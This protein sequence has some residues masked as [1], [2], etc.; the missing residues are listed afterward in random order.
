MGQKLL[1]VP[2][3]GN[4]GGCPAVMR[5]EG[6]GGNPAAHRDHRHSWAGMRSSSRQVEALNIRT[7]IGR[8]ERTIPTAVARNAVDRSI[9]H[10]VPLM[11]IKRRE[12]TLK[13]NALLDVGETSS[14]LQLIK[15]HLA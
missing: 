15:N 12:R 5:V 11:D 4:G 13:D 2:P 6:V 9:Q 7:G 8:L 1:S 10:P 3:R 14:R